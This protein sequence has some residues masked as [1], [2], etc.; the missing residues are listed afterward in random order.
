M[1]RM[2]LWSRLFGRSS[3]GP[4]SLGADPLDTLVRD[5]S[6]SGYGLAAVPRVTPWS[7]VRLTVIFEAYQDNPNYRSLAEARLARQCLSQFWLGAPLDQLEMLYRSEVGV[8]YRTLLAGPL[9]RESLTLEEKAWKSALTQRLTSSFDRPETTNVLLAAM[10]YFSPGEMRVADPV[11][12]VPDWLQ[13][14][15]ARL[16][17]HDLLQRLWRPA[18]LLSP[19]GQRYG[20]APA[21]GLTAN[22]GPNLA[23]A[24]EGSSETRV[25]EKPQPPQL[26]R[27]SRQKGAEALAMVQGAD[28]LNRMNGLINLYVID[29]GDADV[30]MQLVELRR[31]LGQIWLDAQPSQMEELYLNSRFGRLYRDLLASNFSKASLSQEDRLL[32]NQLARLVAD[33]SQPGSIN[34]LMAALPFYPAGKIAFG[35]GEQHMP[36]WLVNEIA[37][38][39]DQP[40]EAAS[41]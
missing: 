7:A 25:S 4:R 2:S 31:V 30:R 35:G 15:Y 33:M 34:A 20:R 14:D 38:I 28:Y 6:A 39:Y 5:P 23:G 21:L 17:D 37:T 18:G 10:P 36:R 16:F 32:R 22:L 26:P 19:A 24:P 8:C 3:A 27:L 13:E 1:N 41:A 29:P 40:R 12:Q 9:S 11:Q